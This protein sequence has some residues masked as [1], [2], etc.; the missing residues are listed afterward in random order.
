MGLLRDH[1]GMKK[2]ECEWGYFL[3]GFLSDENKRKFIV[4]IRKA[5]INLCFQNLSWSIAA[6]T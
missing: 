1:D 6:M 4:Q 3:K 5:N 2:V